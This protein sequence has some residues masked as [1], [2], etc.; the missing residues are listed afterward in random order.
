MM[1]LLLLATIVAMGVT[2]WRMG[3]E[4]VPLRTEL[5]DLRKE[6][7][8]FLVKQPAK[9]HVIQ[10]GEASGKT[11]KWRL[12][13][14]ANKTYQLHIGQGLF[15]DLDQSDKLSWL[16]F[17]ESRRRGASVPLPAGQFTLAASLEEYDSK[18]FFRHAYQNKLQGTIELMP[19]TD[20]FSDL[21]VHLQHGDANCE[22]VKLFD[23][24][25]PVILLH[26]RKGKIHYEGDQW[27]VER[28]VGPTDSLVVWLSAQ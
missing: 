22:E 6:L 11:W 28:P 1:T 16:S 9:I 25:T 2:L 15:E 14:P 10:V 13:L 3:H 23:A 21:L 20:W 24:S 4:V 27:S 12:H 17:V 19:N 8:Y 18:W 5:R 7:G 26:V